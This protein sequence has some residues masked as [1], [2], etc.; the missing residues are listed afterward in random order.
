MYTHG[1]QLGAWND[2]H[3]LSPT[4]S[5][6]STDSP[7][8]SKGY[9]GCTPAYS[10]DEMASVLRLLIEGFGGEAT[11]TA[12]MRHS[13]FGRRSLCGNDTTSAS[14]LG[15]ILG[16]LADCG[17]ITLDDLDEADVIARIAPHGVVL[18]YK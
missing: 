10:V 13:A 14:W 7:A 2:R 6:A 12:L 15:R 4:P 18:A 17:A 11:S 9:I 5:S 3:R 1:L 8:R 16:K